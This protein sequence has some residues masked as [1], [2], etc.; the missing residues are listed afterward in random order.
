METEPKLL[1]FSS[2]VS[3]LLHFADAMETKLKLL[4]FSSCVSL[5]VFCR[6]HGN[7]AELADVFIVCF[8]CCILQ[9]PWKQ[10]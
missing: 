2:C 1:T 9:T 10:S 7:R 4:T 6:R 8:S 5:V 3:V